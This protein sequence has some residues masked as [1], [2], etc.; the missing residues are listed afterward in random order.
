VRNITSLIDDSNNAR[1][2][3]FGTLTQKAA[4]V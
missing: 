3:L 4:T 2:S 1:L